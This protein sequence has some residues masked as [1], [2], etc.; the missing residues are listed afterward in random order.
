MKQLSNYVVWFVGDQRLK[1]GVTSNFGKRMQYYRQEAQRH[2]LGHVDGIHCPALPAA[3][4]R[5]IE[6]DICR[7]LK[8]AAIPGHREWFTGDASTYDAFIA[9]TRRMHAQVTEVMQGATHA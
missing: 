3:V 7:A 9:M 1:V 8:P 4:A 2:G 6:A 5:G